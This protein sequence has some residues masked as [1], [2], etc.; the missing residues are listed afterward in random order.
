L[1]ARL[2]PAHFLFSLVRM[3][4]QLHDTPGNWR[5]MTADQ[6][7]VSTL[8][9]HRRRPDHAAAFLLRPGRNHAVAA[10]VRDRLPQ[11]LVLI[12][13]N[14]HQRV[15]L[16]HVFS[17]QFHPC[18]QVLVGKSRNRFLQICVRSFQSFLKFPGSVMGAGCAPVF[19]VPERACAN[20]IIRA[21]ASASAP[22]L[23]RIFVM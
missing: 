23:V 3:Q 13:E 4:I 8:L 19:G 22:Y 17:E 10:R 16:R 20:G 18:L 11:V 12:F 21:T 1:P 9:A 15:L 6:D 2:P 7:A 14:Q 5:D